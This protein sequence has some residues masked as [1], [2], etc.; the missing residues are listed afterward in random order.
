MDPASESTKIFCALEF[1]VEHN[2]V[3]ISCSPVYHESR[4]TSCHSIGRLTNSSRCCTTCRIIFFYLVN[5]HGNQ[6]DWNYHVHMSFFCIYHT[7]KQINFKKNSKKIIH[8]LFI[9]LICV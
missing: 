7:Y 9:L 4:T 5:L 3:D 1:E 8:V 6:Y 2:Y